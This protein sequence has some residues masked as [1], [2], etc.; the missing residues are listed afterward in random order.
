MTIKLL[1]PVDPATPIS[2]TFDEH[3]AQGRKN[4]NGAVDFACPSGTLVRA[5]AAGQVIR[6][7]KD[8]TGYG[9]HVRIKHADGYMTLYAHLQVA[10]VYFLTQVQAGD[11]IG[12][13]DNTGNSTGPHLHFEL[14]KDNIPIDPAPYLY[15]EQAQGQPEP[16][17]EIM[18]V[19][20]DVLNVRSG[21]GVQ[22][23][24]VG[25]LHAGDTVTPFKLAG[26]VW[27]KIGPDEYVAWVYGQDVYLSHE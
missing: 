26:E 17:G 27:V 23:P 24:L 21:P 8:D 7:G 12:I 11:I 13:S 9:V 1:Y 2:Q 3:V 14:R 22:Y 25:R 18:R 10:T 4:Y 16:A 19:A 20:V 6:A 15:T 5:A